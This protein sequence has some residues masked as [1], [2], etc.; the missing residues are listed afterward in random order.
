MTKKKRNVMLVSEENRAE[1]YKLKYLLE[2]RTFDD[3]LKMLLDLY[4]KNKGGKLK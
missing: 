1:L 4:Y 2:L 3:V